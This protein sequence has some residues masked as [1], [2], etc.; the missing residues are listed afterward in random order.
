MPSVIDAMRILP[1]IVVVGDRAGI[2][3]LPVGLI[4]HGVDI[5]Q[6]HA[7][8]D[9]GRTVQSGNREVV[10]AAPDLVRWVGQV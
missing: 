2:D 1:L 10:A 9:Q 7:G 4:G 5:A 8:S 6:R 3:G